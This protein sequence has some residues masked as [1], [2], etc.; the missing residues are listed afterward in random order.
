M[1][2]KR[3]PDLQR[4]L[5]RVDGF[6][7]EHPALGFPFAVL[8]KFGDD[9]GGNLAALITYYGFVS[10]FPL[11][12]VSVTVLG[13]LLHDNPDLQAKILDSAL[14]NFPIIGDQIRANVTT[15]GGTGI[16]LAVGVLF[17]LYGG[18]GIANVTQH[19]LNRI[20]GVPV[21][22]RPGFLPRL[23]RSLA[24]IAIIGLAILV[25]TVLSSIG[26]SLAP[27]LLQSLGVTLVAIA[28]NT[29]LFEIGFQVTIVNH[30]SWRDLLPGA[31]AAGIAWELLQRLGTF[32]VSRV[33][34]GMSQVYGLFAL[35]LGLLVWISLQARVVLYAAE[36][37]AVRATRLWPRSL[38]PPLTEADRRAN[39]LYV[40]IA[41]RR[42]DAEATD[43]PVTPR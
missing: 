2:E 16:A 39:A 11:L 19:A 13:Y 14:A 33:L 34:Q 32:Y 24:L 10:L 26:I 9:R 7:Q 25:T 8:K 22:A 12:L 6:Q 1:V 28:C 5:S 30:V 42:A 18:L 41:Q 20:W 38:A 3:M 17:T 29:A 21:H 35:V 23:T 4:G 43:A 36:I 40:R 31:I 37:S 15:V 27:D